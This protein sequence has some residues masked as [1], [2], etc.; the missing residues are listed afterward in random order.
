[1]RSEATGQPGCLGPLTVDGPSLPVG[2]LDLPPLPVDLQLT[3]DGERI[4]A[5]LGAMPVG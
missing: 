5:E 1:M 4:T 2:A 3:G